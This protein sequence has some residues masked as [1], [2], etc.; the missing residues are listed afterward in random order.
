[1]RSAGR[2]LD[3]R[4]TRL[5]DSVAAAKVSEFFLRRPTV[6]PHGSVTGA[7]MGVAPTSGV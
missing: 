4:F 3:L 7:W 5:S 2:A 1:M 6:R